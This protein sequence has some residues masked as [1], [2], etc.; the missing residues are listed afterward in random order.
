MFK[1]I[2]FAVFIVIAIVLIFA[3][4]RP[5]T[6]HVDASQ[7]IKAPPE[8]IFPYLNNLHAWNEWSPFEKGIEMKKTYS[9]PEE[10]VGASL[11]FEGDQSGSGTSTIFG[12]A[13]PNKIYI[14]LVMTKPLHCDNN[15]VLTLKPQADGTLVNWAMSGHVSLIGKIMGLFF[16][17]KMVREQ[18]A[19]GLANL[20]TLVET[21]SAQ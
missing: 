21:N 18:F 3:S 16:S 13:Y 2:L 19:T 8:K 7:V 1:K 15:V 4:T 17:D 12:S 5:D 10:G 20:K 6:F 9:G 14:R 11:K